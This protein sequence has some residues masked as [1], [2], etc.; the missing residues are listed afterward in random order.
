MTELQITQEYFG[1]STHLVYLAPLWREFFDADTFTKGAGSPVSKVVD[2][3]AHRGG[4]R[5]CRRRQ[6]R[7]RP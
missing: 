1:Q 2:G 4:N 5:H 7:Q 3:I 6:H